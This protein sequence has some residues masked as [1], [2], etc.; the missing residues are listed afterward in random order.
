MNRPTETRFRKMPL[1]PFDEP[2]NA[3]TALPV[4]VA[5]PKL[6]VSR[7]PKPE[8][9]SA[10]QVGGGAGRT[11]KAKSK[12]NTRAKRTVKIACGHVLRVY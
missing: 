12:Q 1:V 10:R 5:L 6:A 11:V 4:G 9:G 8:S 7:K 2:V 3:A